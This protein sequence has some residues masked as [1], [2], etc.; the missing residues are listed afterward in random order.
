MTSAAEEAAAAAAMLSPRS[1]AKY[2]ERQAMEVQF[3]QME[4]RLRV[5]ITDLLKPTI[6]KQTITS[7]DVEHLK[8][9]VMQHSRGLQ[10][11]QLQQ[12]KIQEQMGTI[13]AF[14]EDMTRWDGER[15]KHEADIDAKAE[16]MSQRM[17]GFKY[18]LEQKESALH[19]LHRSVDRLATELNHVLEDID[20]N[21]EAVETRIDEQSRRASQLKSEIEV[22]I[23]G[24]ELKHNAL[25]DELWSEETG[26]ARVAGELK[27]TNA[28][29][30]TLEASVAALE[31]GKAEAAQLDRLRVEVGKMVHEANTSVAT[32]RQNVGNVVNDVR[33][34]FKTASQ[35]ISAH[36]ATFISEV[37]ASYQQELANAAKLRGEVQDFMGEVAD[38]IDALDARVA[39]AASKADTLAAEAQEEIEELNRRRKSDK[40]SSDTELKALKRRLG[41]VF[42]NSD[43]VLRGIEHI[44]K[45]IGMMLDSDLIQ[46]S[47]ERQDSVD[48]A[49][50]ALLGVK[51]TD[52]ALS[53]T[54]QQEPQR[55]RPECRGKAQVGYPAKDSTP[56]GGGLANTSSSAG[57]KSQQAP[58][59][60][61]DNRCLSC[62]GQAPLVLSAF[63]IACLQYTPSP[64]EHDG[65]QHDR[66]ELLDRRHELLETAHGALVTGPIGGNGASGAISGGASDQSP[67]GAS[68]SAGGVFAEYAAVEARRQQGQDGQVVRLPHLKQSGLLTAR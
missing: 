53:R 37:R 44:Y 57:G 28:A 67:A 9:Q 13:A 62:S 66:A 20:T 10:E 5:A 51:D 21:R 47:L 4:S 27:K 45:V 50:I 49:R 33:E 65:F 7:A 59:V 1:H 25:T 8:T 55:A 56:R 41:G 2:D 24:L 23:A 30:G 68:D 12:Y 29:F 40:S 34:H 18:S 60:R 32:L 64:V 19:H 11:V 63:K 3:A 54:Y 52:A 26:L 31:E 17:D 39:A 22:R 16:H 14:R 38:R 15:H 46:C 48:R 58:V 35:T 6:E 36:N 61:V 42:E 43:M